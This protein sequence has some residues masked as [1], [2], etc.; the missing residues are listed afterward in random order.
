MKPKTFYFGLPLLLILMAA[1]ALGWLFYDLPSTAPEA[2]VL[3]A[4]GVRITDRGGQVLYEVQRDQGGSQMSVPLEKIPLALRQAT[5]DTE[6]SRFYSNP[7]VDLIGLLRAVW[8][9][10][11]SGETL[12]GGSTITQQVARNLLLPESERSQ[13]TPR[14]KLRE[15]LLAW[16]LAQRYSKNEILALYLNQTYYGGMTYGVETAARTYFGK[17]LD[18]LSLA[19][20]A[21]LAGLPQAPALYN[22]YTDTAAARTR[23]SVVLELMQKNGDIDAGQAKLANDEP[24][25]LAGTP[26]PLE[27]PHFVM[28][29]RAQVDNLFSPEEIAASGGLVVRTSLNLAWQHSAEQAVTR[30]LAFLHQQG[31]SSP[32]HNVNNAAVVALDPHS[33]DIL[34]MVGSPDF[35]DSQHNG[36][37][38]MATAPRQPGSSLKPFIYALSFD[39]AQ[40]APWTP[41]SLMLDVN[42]HFHTR[43]GG[44]YTPA[45]FDRQEHGPVLVR[46][47]L[48]SSLNIPAVAALEHVGLDSLL[49]FLQKAGIS[50]L[51]SAQDLDLSLALGGGEISLL[52]L[53]SAYGAF[54]SGG[55][56]VTRRAILDVR[57]GQGTLLYSAPAADAGRIMDSRVAWLISD[58]LS[59]DS[60]RSLGFPA[61][62]VLNLDRPTAVKTGTTSNYHDNWTMGYTPD[63]VVGVWVGNAGQEPMYDVT[64]LSGAGPIWHAVMRDLLAGSPQQSFERPAGLVQKTICALSG[65]LP[66]PF[67]TYTRPEWFIEGTAP[68]RADTFYRQV[69]LDKTSGLPAGPQTA[70][71]DRELATALDLPPQAL[72]WARQRGLLLWTDLESGKNAG[73]STPG[74]AAPQSGLVLLTPGDGA[75]YTLSASLPAANQQMR[76]EASG[77]STAGPVTFLVDGRVLAVVD[78]PPYQA[79]WPLALGKHHIQAQVKDAGGSIISSSLVEITVQGE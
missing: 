67:C 35:N 27:A 69:V 42:T 51:G 50:S 76:I 22:P 68:T 37:I 8:I 29:V 63:L 58:I 72:P 64:G 9:N 33:G 18:Q 12:S 2:L 21:L 5:I 15:M 31:A 3:H 53:T 13:R 38:N 57:D 1:A 10:L 32:S 7:G 56:R 24:I 23:R 73:A 54:A 75:V 16:Q 71:G 11:G 79:W 30:Q 14:R 47:A 46:Q 43:D 55:L 39:P 77:G 60:A 34:T 40:S 6:D 25:R 41:A 65:M 74:A 62:S 49:V 44:V 36:A 4:P 26:Y 66:S 45:D 78:S 61:H 59:D 17:S 20:S 28:W 19:E 48:A 70:P 52:K